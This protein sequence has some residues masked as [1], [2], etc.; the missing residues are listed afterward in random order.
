MER[1]D[2]LCDVKAICD[3]V[4]VAQRAIHEIEIYNTVSRSNGKAKKLDLMRDAGWVG[5]E[6]VSQS[7][8]VSLTDIGAEVAHRL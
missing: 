2:V 6:R 8:T 4:P 5:I 7:E 3:D 1:F